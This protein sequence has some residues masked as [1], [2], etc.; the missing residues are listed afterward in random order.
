MVEARLRF[1]YKWRSGCNGLSLYDFLVFFKYSFLFFNYLKFKTSY[2]DLLLNKQILVID[3]TGKMNI[4]YKTLR[5]IKTLLNVSDSLVF[6]EFQTFHL[7]Q[8][9]L[10]L[11]QV[12]FENNYLKIKK[13][14]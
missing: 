14:F 1:F 11:L 8:Y 6:N 9:S 4:K 7:T 13:F 5:K 2:S 12:I 10:L 3:L